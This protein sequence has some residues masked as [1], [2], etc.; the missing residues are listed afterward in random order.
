MGNPSLSPPRCRANSWQSDATRV[1]QI[2]ASMLLLL[3]WFIVVGTLA[4]AEICGDLIRKLVEVA[5]R[6]R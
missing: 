6:R 3:A 4:A 5:G 1:L 2:A